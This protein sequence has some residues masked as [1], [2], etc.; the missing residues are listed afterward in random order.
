MSLN[1]YFFSNVCYWQNVTLTLQKLTLLNTNV[2][3]PS[4]LASYVVTALKGI[5]DLQTFN[6]DISVDSVASKQSL[7]SL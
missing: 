5:N 6:V 7:A 4:D 1:G 3:Q 2:N